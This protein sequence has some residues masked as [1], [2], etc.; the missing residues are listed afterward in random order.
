MLSFKSEGKMT[1]FAAHV[2]DA[3][4]AF[5]GYGVARWWSKDETSDPE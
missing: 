3:I 2:I 4:I 1:G 5:G